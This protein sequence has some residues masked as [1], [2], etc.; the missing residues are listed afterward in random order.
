MIQLLLGLALAQ[1]VDPDDPAWRDPFAFRP[2]AEAQPP[3]SDLE[4][5]AIRNALVDQLKDG[6]SAKVR[7]PPLRSPPGEPVTYCAWVNAKNGYGAYSGYKAFA[8]TYTG[9]GKAFRVLTLKMADDVLTDEEYQ[10]V[11]R[12]CAPAGYDLSIGPSK[13]P[14]I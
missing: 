11:K 9:R 3:L 12:T 5:K 10:A 13:F 2:V 8:V 1:A 7:W 14:E 4:R 6:E